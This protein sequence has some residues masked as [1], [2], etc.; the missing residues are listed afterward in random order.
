MGRRLDTSNP[1]TLLCHRHSRRAPNRAK[2]RNFPEKPKAPHWS[3]MGASLPGTQTCRMGAK[4]PQFYRRYSAVYLIRR[5]TRCG[6]NGRAWLHHWA[7]F[8]ARLLLR[9]RMQVDVRT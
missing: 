1:I 2:F 4:H 5:R 7:A 9:E 6:L 8:Q 3:R